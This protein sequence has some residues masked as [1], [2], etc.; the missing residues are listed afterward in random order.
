MSHVEEYRQLGDGPLGTGSRLQQTIDLSGS[1]VSFELQV[2]RYEPP[3][4]AQDET[5]QKAAQALQSN[6]VYVDPQAELSGRVDPGELRGRIER[7]NAG[8]MYVAVLPDSTL[9]SHGGSAGAV[10]RALHAAVGRRG[11]YL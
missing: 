9:S 1:R 10:L 8:P 7:Q 5:I 2:L 6:P 3:R 4:V 11:T